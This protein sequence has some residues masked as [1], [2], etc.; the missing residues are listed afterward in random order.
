MSRPR[1]YGTSSPAPRRPPSSS[2]PDLC[3]TLSRSRANRPYLLSERHPITT[4]PDL[5]RLASVRVLRPITRRPHR[6]GSLIPLRESGGVDTE[7]DALPLPPEWSAGATLAQIW[8]FC[9][10]AGA[11]RPRTEPI[12]SGR[13]HPP[14]HI[15]P[16][17]L[18]SSLH[19]PQRLISRGEQMRAKR[20]RPQIES[21]F[22]GLHR[23]PTFPS[24]H[25]NHRIKI[26]RF[27]ASCRWC[28]V[29][30]PS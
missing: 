29:S 2:P 5:R 28:S 3:K 10:V 23:R 21:D 18:P 19:S 13:K 9:G 30:I 4:S 17:P 26:A 7:V 24:I 25:Q 1:R 16:H 11:T 15:W 14:P 27:T 8:G 6:L 20:R 12:S 22:L